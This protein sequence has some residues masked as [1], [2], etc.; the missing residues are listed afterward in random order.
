MKEIQKVITLVV[1]FFIFYLMYNFW[2]GSGIFNGWLEPSVSSGKLGA[3]NADLLSQLIEMVITVVSTV[4][5]VGITI[6]FKLIRW[7]STPFEPLLES[8][9][10]DPNEGYVSDYRRYSKVEGYD[11]YLKVLEQ[12]IIDGNPNGVEFAVNKMHGS[13]FMTAKEIAPAV[14]K[15]P[16]GFPIS[17]GDE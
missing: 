7:L 4:G 5:L 12:A 14:R 9:V 15:S 1:G 16:G 11:T 10:K 6:S 17:N 13:D 2:F 3:G 8:F